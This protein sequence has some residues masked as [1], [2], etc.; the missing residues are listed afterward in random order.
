LRSANG[1]KEANDRQIRWV[2]VKDQVIN[3]AFCGIHLEYNS[4]STSAT[5]C[6]AMSAT[7][8]TLFPKAVI[9]DAYGTLFDVHSVVAAAEQMFPGEGGALAALASQADRV[10]AVAHARTPP[11]RATSRSGTSRSTRCA[12]PRAA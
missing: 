12:T 6:K 7:T 9:F 11:A 1:C 10:H 2:K 8:T 5:E 4:T 3:R